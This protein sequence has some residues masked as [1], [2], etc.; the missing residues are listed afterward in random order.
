[1][2]NYKY[3]DF[4]QIRS[5]KENFEFVYKGNEYVRHSESSIRKLVKDLGIRSVYI[6]RDDDCWVIN[7]HLTQEWIFTPRYY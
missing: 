6:T 3:M 2:G 7:Q 4:G 1:M 5:D